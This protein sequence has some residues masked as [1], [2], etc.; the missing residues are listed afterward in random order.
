MNGNLEKPNVIIIVVDTLRKDYAKNLEGKLKESGF[1]S[2]ENAIAPAPWTIPSHASIFTGLYP[3]THKSH[4][5]KKTKI[6]YIKFKSKSQDN[7]LTDMSI[8]GYESFLL[9]ANPFVSRVFNVKGFMHY[10][11]FFKSPSPL[12]ISKEESHYVNNLMEN[13]GSRIRAAAKLLAS[14]K[15]K[16]LVKSSIG[17]LFSH[18]PLST[19]YHAIT[20]WPLYKGVNKFIKLLKEDVL[21]ENL[22]KFIFINLMEV[23][24]PYTIGNPV[25]QTL[26]KINFKPQLMKN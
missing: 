18:R 25:H 15:L 20:K 10:H 8:L 16:I 6:P 12:Q 21:I 19:V 24:E 14:K 7:I 9:S 1:I 3:I 11:E 23:H 17:F 5:N 26:Q 22:P 4:E 13:Y 2:Y